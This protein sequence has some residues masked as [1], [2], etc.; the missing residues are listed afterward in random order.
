MKAGGHI[1]PSVILGAKAHEKKPKKKPKK[2]K[3]LPIL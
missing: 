1:Q 3:K 2:K